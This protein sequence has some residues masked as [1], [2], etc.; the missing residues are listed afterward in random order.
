MPWTNKDFP[1][2]M[3]NLKEAIRAKAIEIANRLVDTLSYYSSERV[4]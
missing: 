3:K 2:S 1:D 4:V